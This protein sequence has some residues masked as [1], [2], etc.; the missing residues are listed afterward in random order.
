[1]A[2]SVE[3]SKHTSHPIYYD[4]KSSF[5]LCSITKDPPN[6]LLIC[7]NSQYLQAYTLLHQAMKHRQLKYQNKTKRLDFLNS[8][9]YDAL[10]FNEAKLSPKKRENNTVQQTTQISIQIQFFK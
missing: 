1:M 6:S 10:I 7:I 3:K 9:I 2:F 4:S 8:N 5:Q